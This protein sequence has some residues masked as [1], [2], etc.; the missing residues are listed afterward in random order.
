M[1]IRLL[2][3]LTDRT[4]HTE[5]KLLKRSKQKSFKKLDSTV[6]IACEL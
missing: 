1:Y 6:Y 4:K 5:S 3:K 2:H